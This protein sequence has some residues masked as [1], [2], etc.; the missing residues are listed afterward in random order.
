MITW[1]HNPALAPPPIPHVRNSSQWTNDNKSWAPQETV[2]PPST[3][4][5]K[6]ISPAHSY[7][8]WY[9]Y[10]SILGNQRRRG[11]RRNSWVVVGSGWHG[12]SPAQCRTERME[13]PCAS[14]WS[15]SPALYEGWMYTFVPPDNRRNHPEIRLTRQYIIN[16][17]LTALDQT[18]TPAE[19]DAYFEKVL[20]SS[21]VSREG[22]LGHK[23]RIWVLSYPERE[24]MF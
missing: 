18:T 20:Q 8:S 1:R 3:C 14:H 23:F 4:P 13:I 11:S 10:K 24:K 5:T 17:L 21:E 16:R 15:S 7:S 6:V 22:K 12:P 2:Q 19:R 9:G